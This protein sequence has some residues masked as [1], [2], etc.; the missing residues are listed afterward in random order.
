ML[1]GLTSRPALGQLPGL[2]A[3]AAAKGSAADQGRRRAVGEKTKPAVATSSGPITVH[4]Q[5]HDEDIERFLDR[6]LPKYP[7]VESLET[8]VEQG[9]VTL[10]GTGRRR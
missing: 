4:R 3:A 5:V 9:V 10:T 6:F 2:P 8:A 7:G 1:V